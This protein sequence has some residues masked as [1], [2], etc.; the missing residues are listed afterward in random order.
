MH[1]GK[2]MHKPFM[3]INFSVSTFYLSCSHYDGKCESPEGPDGI[4]DEELTSSCYLHGH[5]TDGW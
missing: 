5:E 4:G 3:Y 2:K 1:I